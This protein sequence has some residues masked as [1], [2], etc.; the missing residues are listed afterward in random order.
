MR[1]TFRLGRRYQAVSFRITIVALWYLLHHPDSKED[2]NFKYIKR[3]LRK[4]V[5]VIINKWK[6]AHS[7]GISDFIAEKLII[8]FLEPKDQIRF[9]KILNTLKEHDGILNKKILPC[10]VKLP[11]K[12]IGLF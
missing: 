7:N 5:A 8:S 10:G 2:R 1:G 3:T 9:K 4:Y 11:K 12:E 6:Y